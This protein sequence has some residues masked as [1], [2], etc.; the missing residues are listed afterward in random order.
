MGEKQ[1]LE[2]QGSEKP[3]KY[4]TRREVEE[5]ERESKVR[6]CGETIL[7]EMTDQDPWVIIFN[8]YIFYLFKGSAG[9]Y[10]EL[11]L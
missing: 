9:E 7:H 5:E 1:G 3:D 10:Q 2:K 6:Q 11:A 4:Q 8:K